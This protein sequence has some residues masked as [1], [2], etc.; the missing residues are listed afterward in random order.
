VSVWQA[1]GWGGFSSAALYIGEALAGP[2]EKAHRATGMVM[3][4]GAGT[5]LSAVAYELI[6]ETNLHRGLGI[7]IGFLTGALVYYVGDRL[8]DQG[9]GGDRQRIGGGPQGGSGAAMFLGALLDGVPEACILGISL[10]PW[11]VRSASRLLRRCLSP[12]SPKASPARP[13]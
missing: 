7:G 10:A 2:M 12:T 1:L 8:I 5:L 4:F 3:G 13:A 11:A 9:G 6:P